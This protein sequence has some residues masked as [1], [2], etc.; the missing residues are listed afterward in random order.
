MNMILLKD[1]V[2]AT[3]RLLEQ[4]IEFEEKI[5]NKSDKKNLKDIYKMQF[6]ISSTLEDFDSLSAIVEKMWSIGLEFKQLSLANAYKLAVMQITQDTS[7]K[8]YSQFMKFLTIFSDISQS[9]S[10]KVAQNTSNI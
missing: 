4:L 8:T 9:L 2:E 5:K 10:I 3:K 1:N 6:D 7:T